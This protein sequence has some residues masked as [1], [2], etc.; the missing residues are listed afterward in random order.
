MDIASEWNWVL[1]AY[2]FAYVML[3]GYVASVAT[4]ISRAKRRLGEGS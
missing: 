2:G 3:A 4:R 1:L